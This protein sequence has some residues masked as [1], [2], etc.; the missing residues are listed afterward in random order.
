[1][2]KNLRLVLWLECET[3]FPLTGRFPEIS[4]TR[5]IAKKFERA[6]MQ[7]KLI[8]PNR[9]LIFIPDESA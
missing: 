8:N 5:A 9:D 6:K 4:H 2:G 3:L 7:E 1:L